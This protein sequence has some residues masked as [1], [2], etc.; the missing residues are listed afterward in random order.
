MKKAII[1]TTNNE[2]HYNQ[3]M[4]CSVGDDLYV[5]YNSEIEL[6]GIIELLNY[7]ATTRGYHFRLDTEAEECKSLQPIAGSQTGHQPK[8]R[9]L[10]LH[11]K[12]TSRSIN[13]ND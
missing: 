1:P 3:I 9:S 6:D 12:V 11:V 8:R 2:R 10:L 13:L 5:F 4:N 7:A